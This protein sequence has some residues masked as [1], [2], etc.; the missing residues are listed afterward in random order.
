[1]IWDRPLPSDDAVDRV[2]DEIL[3]PSLQR[4]EAEGRLR[5]PARYNTTELY[6]AAMAELFRVHI[7]LM[8]EGTEPTL[9]VLLTRT[10]FTLDELY[11]LLDSLA[12]WALFGDDLWLRPSAAGQLKLDGCSLIL[13]SA[14]RVTHGANVFATLSPA[15]PT[16]AY[17][18]LSRQGR[19]PETLAP[20]NADG[21]ESTAYL[22][23][24]SDHWAI[25]RRVRPLPQGTRFDPATYDPDV[26][27]LVEEMLVERLGEYDV[28]TRDIIRDKMLGSLLT[29]IASYEDAPGL[30]IESG[31]LPSGKRGLHFEFAGS[32]LELITFIEKLGAVPFLDLPR[33]IWTKAPRRKRNREIKPGP[34]VVRG[35][36]CSFKFEDDVELPAHMVIV[37]ARAALGADARAAHYKDIFQPIDRTIVAL[38]GADPELVGYLYADARVGRPGAPRRS[39][40]RIGL[41]MR[42]VAGAITQGWSVRRVDLADELVQRQ[43][44]DRAERNVAITKPGATLDRVVQYLRKRG[45]QPRTELPELRAQREGLALCADVLLTRAAIPVAPPAH[46]QQKPSA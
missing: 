23:A 17:D 37:A 31:F 36:N 24:V 30:S 7:G 39:R 21:Y 6:H 41:V 32:D 22:I 43:I 8:R 40:L 5:R 12:D 2:V 14:V 35:D 26:R 28:R 25:A 18:A 44:I 16:P 15:L 29:S 38:G 42:T 11:Q 19:L 20:R 46:R 27:G 9:T 1:M 10:G 34:F 13:Q 45:A 3:I 33:V 4:E